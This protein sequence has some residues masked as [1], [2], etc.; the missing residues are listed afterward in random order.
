VLH[1]L[2]GFDGENV[3]CK[4]YDE[5]VDGKREIV[6][7]SREFRSDTPAMYFLAQFQKSDIKKING[8]DE[9]FMKGYAYEDNDFGERWVRAGIPFKIVDEIRAVHQYHERGETI[10]GGT[11]VN[12]LKFYDNT[13]KG[14]IRCKNGLELL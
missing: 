12:Q 3:L 10:E 2:S 13:D 14:I 4:V 11:V 9:D 6:L 7:V 1:Q 8:W 5:E